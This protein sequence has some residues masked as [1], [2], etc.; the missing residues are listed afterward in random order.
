MIE[1][2]NGWADV[3]AGFMWR[4]LVEGSLLLAIACLVW[5]PLKRR[6]PAQVGY[7][8]FLLVMLKVCVPV[9]V[10]VPAWLAYVSPRYS[11]ERLVTWATTT[12]V[13]QP[14]IVAVGKPPDFELSEIEPHSRSFGMQGSER[15]GK[16]G[17]AERQPSTATAASAQP[18]SRSAWLMFAWTTLVVGLA[19]R[20][21]M[22]QW[23]M[24]QL[25]AEAAPLDAAALGVD[26]ELLRRLAG[27]RWKVE[28][29][30]TSA[31]A[32]PAVSGL[33]KPRIVLP[34]ELPG[35]LTA[36]Q[37]TFAL[38]HELAHIRRCDLPVVLIQRLVQIVFFFNPAVWIANWLID[39]ER[40]YACDDAALAACSFGRRDCGQ[41]F[42]RIVEFASARPTAV[43]PAL[44]LF[45][46]L[47][48]Y[49]IFIRSRLMRILDTRRSVH[50]RLSLSGAAILTVLA[51]IL[52]PQV[53]A[54]QR[55]GQANAADD[56]KKGTNGVAPITAGSAT[57][58]QK[59]AGTREAGALRP[60]NVVNLAAVEAVQKDLGVSPDVASKLTLLRNEYRAAVQKEYQDAGINPRDFGNPRM[61]AEQRQK[62]AEIGR[63]LDDEFISKA[64]ELLTADQNKRFQQ[65]Q[66]QYRLSSNGPRALLAPDVA[67][68]LKLTDDQQQKLNALSREFV[69]KQRDLMASS[70]G[71]KTSSGGFRIGGTALAEFRDGLAKIGEEHRTKA[72]EV[73]TAEQKESLTKLTGNEFDVSRIVL[74]APPG[75]GPPGS[76]I[77]QQKGTKSGGAVMPQPGD[78]LFLLRSKAVQNDLG[79]SDEVA[80]KLDSLSVESRAAMEKEWQDAGIN[81]RDFPFRDSP[82]KLRKHQDI[83]KKNND[84]F[85]QKG[86]ELLTAD[87]YKRLQQIHFQYRLR[88]NA[89]RTLRAPDVA[90]ELKLTYDQARTLSAIGVDFT[91]AIPSFGGTNFQDHRDEYNIKAIDL[92][93]AEQKETLGKLKG[94]DV[95]LS[96]FFPRTI[97]RKANVPAGPEI[98]RQKNSGTPRVTFESDNIVNIAGVEAVQKDL[99]VSDEVARKLTL[100]R[101][102]YRAALQKEYQAADV[103]PRFGPNQLSL[104]QRQKRIE[105]GRSLNDRFFPK[106]VELLS[107]DQQRRLQQIQFQS[108]LRSRGPGAL[109]MPDVASELKL[110]DDQTQK[111]NTLHSEF[112]RGAFPTASS[113]K[114]KERKDVAER[115]MKHREEFAAKTKELLT[116]AMEVLT[117]EQKETLN[118]LEGNEF[119]LS[120]LVTA[121]PPAKEN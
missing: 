119:D 23:R 12:S 57:A 106:A 19:T 16:G 31:V 61:T 90:S 76:S 80:S 42:L 54:Q 38:L 116:K 27:V 118:K 33:W 98:A 47:S 62:Y 58:Q 108:R 81:L 77:A 86:K 41:G 44:G 60:D 39:R 120:K 5:L 20:F 85:G 8:L 40:E 59:S 70:G 21:V 51:A 93:T 10:P 100:L 17:V 97:Q 104:E 11:L 35:Q 24:R 114:S 49:R 82:E 18:L 48:T 113:F 46:G 95:N 89:E 79:V 26:V 1:A 74:A 34:A 66:F 83:Q 2:M 110:T 101:D 4:G 56:G 63:K 53:R 87:Q 65:I 115:L 105:I 6:V 121:R 55:A 28:I 22:V 96:M 68:E 75:M 84:E 112:M 43:A 91:R 73:L 71:Q 111:L 109:V 15:D 3:W 52:L 67:P 69:Q 29:V 103:S 25:L 45:G 117:A 107:V 50:S 64:K 94:N 102:E 72:M 9:Q 99:G 13:G 37:V 36:N 30:S 32:A 92:L 88:Q 7:C 78:G 14:S